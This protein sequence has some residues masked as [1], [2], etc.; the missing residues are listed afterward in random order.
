MF[1]FTSSGHLLLQR[2]ATGKYHF[3]G[4]WSNS[5]CGHPRPGE[6]VA[7]GAGRRLFE[8]LG[9]SCGLEEVGSFRYSA[10]DEAS[11][12]VELEVDHVLVGVSDAEPAPDPAE[13]DG[14]RLVLMEDLAEGIRADPAAYTPWL[15]QASELAATWRRGG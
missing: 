15:A 10:T 13:V 6:A 1:V 2:R 9:I 11:G 12:L 3:A 7:T 8:E 5:C 4:R 14:V